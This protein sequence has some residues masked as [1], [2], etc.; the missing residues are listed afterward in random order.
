MDALELTVDPGRPASAGRFFSMGADLLALLDELTDLPVAWRVE[1]LRTGSAVV[2]LAPPEDGPAEA[3]HLRVVVDSLGAVQGGGPLPEDWTPDAVKAAHRFVEDG[4]ATENEAGWAPPRLRLV[5]DSDGGPAV[6]LTPTLLKGLATL[7]PFERDMPGAV[8]GTL[9]GFNVSRG[10]R[11]SLRLPT[12]RVIRVGFPSG[13]RERM[14][15]S[16]LQ[17]VELRGTV[18]Q[19]G[20]GRVFKVV[21]DEVEVLHEPSVRWAD[22]FGAAPDYTGGVPADEWLEANR[23]EA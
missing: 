18:R 22:M 5:R 10:N 14:R 16:L 8:R 6:D 13:L 4:Q 21:A 15:D 19:D 23:G 1:D 12:R 7:Q 3:R 2:L 11:A 20:E 9:V 17:D